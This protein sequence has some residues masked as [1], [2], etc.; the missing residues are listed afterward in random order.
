MAQQGLTQD[1]ADSLWQELHA[2][3]KA[4]A[5]HLQGAGTAPDEVN[6]SK[7]EL[8]Q[9]YRM[10]WWDENWRMGELQR[11]GPTS[12]W[13]NYHESHGYGVAPQVTEDMVRG[14]LPEPAPAEPKTPR[15]PRTGYGRQDG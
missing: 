6:V 10:N 9:Y 4:V 1:V 8:H 12:F 15:Q 11:V 13:R 14:P 7:D 2:D 5:A 3:A